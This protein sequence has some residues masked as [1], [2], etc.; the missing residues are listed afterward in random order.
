MAEDIHNLKH[1]LDRDS[2]KYVSRLYP[3]D[4]EDVRRF[5]ND[6]LAQGFTA[7]RV[8]KYLC[9]ITNINERLGIPFRMAGSDDSKR[10]VAWVEKSDYTDWTK[11]DMR[12]MLKKYLQFLGKEDIITWL[13]VK[14]V[15]NG[16]F[17]EEILTEEDIKA[18]ACAAYNSMD[19]AIILSLYE[20]GCR[21]GEFLP[22]S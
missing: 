20:S 7:G 6:L 2:E 13:K 12:V 18:I 3:E 5:T 8:V 19:K 16:T 1:I 22:L 14:S 11:H 21:I 10:Y 4:R 17:P 9:T 15:K